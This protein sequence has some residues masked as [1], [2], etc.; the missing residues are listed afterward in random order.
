MV[1][2]VTEA[3]TISNEEFIEIITTFEILSDKS[4]TYNCYN[5]VNKLAKKAKNIFNARHCKDLYEKETNFID[6]K[7]YRISFNTC[8]GN[9]NS[10]AV[11]EMIVI[12]QNFKEGVMPYPGGLMDQ[13][14]KLV[15][16]LNLLYSLE[17]KQ[18][19]KEYKAMMAKSRAK[20]R[21]RK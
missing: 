20:A 15:E 17:S 7:D 3:N 10:P 16:I 12:M 13:P 19:E 21:T 2:L 1:F 5:C 11:S 9:F 18:V 14:A 8:V 6:A 4:Q